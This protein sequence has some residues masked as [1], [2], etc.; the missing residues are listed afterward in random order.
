M[1]LSNYSKRCNHKPE[2]FFVFLK[3]K[4]FEATCKKCGHTIEPVKLEATKLMLMLLA[5]MSPQ[6]IALAIEIIP[7]KTPIVIRAFSPLA[8]GCPLFLLLGWV[9]TQLVRW[10]KK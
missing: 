8:L 9:A 2:R 1:P 7:I 5:I 6:L 3:S 4:K 10:R